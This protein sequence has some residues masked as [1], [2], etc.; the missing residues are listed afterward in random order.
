MNAYLFSNENYSIT[1]GYKKD[2]YKIA[3]FVVKQNYIHHVGE[4]DKNIQQQIGEVYDEEYEYI[5]NSELFIAKDN[6]ENIIGCIR[7]LK[8]NYIDSLPIEKIFNIDLKE[9][10]DKFSNPTFWHIGRFAI[11]SKS[12]ISNLTL[13]KQLMTFAIKPICSAPNNYF[14][15]ECDSKLLYIMELLGMKTQRL[16]EGI[17]YLGSETIPVYSN[18]DGLIDFYNKHKY[19]C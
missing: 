2:L 16:S 13:F 4:Y 17:F 1:K 14:I 9:L 7:T 19:L 10:I 11:N 12:N 18:R 6:K 15:A 5:R 8:W 3:E